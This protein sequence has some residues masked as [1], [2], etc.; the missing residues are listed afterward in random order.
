MILL[1][2]SWGPQLNNVCNPVLSCHSC[3]LSW[4][5]CPVGVLS[6]FA[7]WQVMTFVAVGTILLVGVLVGRVLCGWVCPFGFIQDLLARIKVKKFTLPAWT[8]YFKYVVLIVTVFLLP[9]LFKPEYSFCVACPAAALEVTVP[10]LIQGESSFSTGT[11]IKLGSLLAVV[12][13]AIFSKRAFCKVLCP[14]GA[15][16][17]PFNYFSFWRV[18][19]PTEN[20]V[21]CHRCDRQCP[22]NIR[23]E[24]KI[25]NEKDPNRTLDCVVCH[26]C[27]DVCP[28]KGK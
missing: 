28:Q 10:S 1:H 7:N 26:K 18:R 15:L 19:K 23:P 12:G 17:A 16:M 27:R 25:K 20:C 21:S 24:K 2:S 11:L 5:A 13:F 9:Y 6:H 4:F 22:A 14:I 3:A 8:G